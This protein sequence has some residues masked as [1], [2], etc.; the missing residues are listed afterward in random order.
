MISQALID[1]YRSRTSSNS[2]R[3]RPTDSFCAT[4]KYVS[5]CG[6]P[7]KLAKLSRC[8]FTA[9]SLHPFIDQY[10]VNEIDLAIEIARMASTYNLVVSACP[11]PTYFAC[12]CSSCDCNVSRVAADMLLLLL[13]LPLKSLQRILLQQAHTHTQQRHQATTRNERE[14]EQQE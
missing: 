4:A 1:W 14:I 13:L 8:W 12:K 2:Y 7:T 11:V 10:S 6:W 3:V 5:M 9:H